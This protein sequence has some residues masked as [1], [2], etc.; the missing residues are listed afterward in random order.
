M[1]PKV[2]T[3]NNIFGGIR[4]GVRFRVRFTVRV[5]VRV[6]SFK[7]SFSI[8]LCTQLYSMLATFGSVSTVFLNL[9][10]HYDLYL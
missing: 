1:V 10:I 9:T 6:N 5:S 2:V 8:L 3:A 4:L 7:D